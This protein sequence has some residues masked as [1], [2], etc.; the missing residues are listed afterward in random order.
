LIFARQVSRSIGALSS[1]AHALGRGG[2]ISSPISS[3]IAELEALGREMGRAAELLHD[4]EKERDR[5]ED[6]LRKQEEFLQRQADLLNLANEAIFAWDSRGTII[7]WNRGAE[8]LY[9]YSESEAIGRVNQELLSTEFS[10]TQSFAASLADKGEWAGELTHKTKTGRRIIVESRLKL[11]RDRAGGGVVLECTRDITN[12]KRTAQ[13]LAM[14]Q[15][16]TRIL[17]ESQTMAEACGN[18]LQTIAESMEWDLALFWTVDRN[19]QALICLETWHRSAKEFPRFVEHSRKV[20]LARGNDLPGRVWAQKEPMWL[21]DMTKASDSSRKQSALDEGLHGAFA[22]PIMLRDEILAVAEFVGEEIR[23]EDRDLLRMVQT[24]GSEV[25]QFI[26][27]VRAE[28]A[29]RRSEERLRD[30]AQ[31]LEQQLMASGR[32]VAVG[33]LTASMAH[34]FNN[35]LGIISGFAQGILGNMDP[36][37]ESYR[38]VQIIAEEAKRCERLV[39]ELLEFGRPKSA[40][41]A[42]TKIDEI[43]NKTVDLINSHAAKN[44]VEIVTTIAQGLPRIYVDAQQLQQVILNLC[45]NAVDAMPTGGK[46][47]LGAAR[48][49]SNRIIITVADTGYGI[50]PETAPKIFQPFFTAKKRRGLGLGLSICDKIVRAHGGGITVQSQ[51]GKGTTFAVHLPL[52]KN[53]AAQ[54][55]TEARAA[56]A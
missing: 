56:Q 11:I 44:N 17:A 25:G 13:R 26:E 31:E 5:V 35:P 19:Q 40:D 7:F 42:L 43:I 37:E 6:A 55:Q 21:S 20:V 27:R 45:L 1:A 23:E 10:E 28:E 39:Q 54:K 41:F 22:F 47:T 32:L 15:A 51:P 24:L 36:S 52:D 53:P 38:H 33:E 12:R 30:Q 16:V 9:G 50:D 29:L 48:D 3:P 34:E 4:R 8:Q 2:L 14:E 46:L 49:S 18:L